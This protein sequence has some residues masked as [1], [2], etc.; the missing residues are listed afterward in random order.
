MKNG[1]VTVMENVTW[2]NKE[3]FHADSQA[4][5]KALKGHRDKSKLS[6]V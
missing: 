6:E 3:T 1:V 4:T 5:L 2:C